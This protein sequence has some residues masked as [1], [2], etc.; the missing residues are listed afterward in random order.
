[1]RKIFI[2][3]SILLSVHSLAQNV[4]IGTTTPAEKLEIKNPLRATLK[5]ST[6]TF[7]DTTE[8]LLSNRNSSNQGTDFSFKSIREEGLFLSSSSD[9]PG[10]NFA[11]SIVVRPNGNV[12]M[13][14]PFSTAKLTVRG[15]EITGDGQ[16]AAIKLQNTASANAWYIRAGATG[17]NTPANGFSIADNSGYHFNMAQ[18]GNIGLGISPSTARLHVNG[19]INLEGLNILEFGAGVAGKEINAGKIG[20]NGFGTNALAIVGA[21]TTSANRA[22]YVFAEGGTTMNGP[23]NI[24][25]PLRINGNSGTTGQVLTSNGTGDPSWADAAYGNT[26]RF[27]FRFE[28]STSAINDFT[29]FT[30]T[31]YNLNT[32]QVVLATNGITIN[33]SGLYRFDILLSAS[34][35][36]ASTPPQ[37]PQLYLGFYNG[38]ASPFNLLNYKPMQAITL[39]SPTVFKMEETYSIEIYVSAPANITFFHNLLSGAATTSFQI[40]GH[41]I[42]HLISE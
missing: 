8:L 32:S 42:G 25:G 24:G 13:G 20:Y 28:E 40:D 34:A 19:M 16:A 7:N 9:L 6:N 3:L 18:G 17:T 27:A 22:V 2:L 5:V 36:F 1:M 31:R 38:L 12:G 29:R 10:N 11:N 23:L 41:L 14:D 35:G 30:G 21:G 26:I 15:N 4:G 39:S 33:Q 37:I